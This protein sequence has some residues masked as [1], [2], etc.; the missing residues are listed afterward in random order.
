MCGSPELQLHSLRSCVL[1]CFR[2]QAYL[3]RKR[4]KTSVITTGACCEASTAVNAAYLLHCIKQLIF[5][6][7]PINASN[8]LRCN[9]TASITA[10]SKDVV[11]IRCCLRFVEGSVCFSYWATN[12]PC[13]KVI[14]LQR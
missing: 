4:L 11:N 1:S 8:D 13:F 2:P 5:I 14:P 6:H 12:Q 9:H 3:L 10:G 7:C